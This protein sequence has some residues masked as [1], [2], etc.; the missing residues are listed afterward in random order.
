MLSGLWYTHVPNYVSLSWFWRC[1]KHP[2]PS[3]PALGLWRILEIPDWGLVLSWFGDLEDAGGSWLGFGIF[4]LIGYGHWS[5]IQLWSKFCL[6]ILSLKMQRTS[7]SFKSWFGALEDPG[8]SWLGFAI[9]ILTWIWSL[10]FDRPMFWIVA[11]YL[12]LEGAKN[13]HVL[14]VLIWGFGGCWRFL[15]WV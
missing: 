13:I 14:K 4:I 9:L 6:S 7:M 10:I 11:L 8:G 2:H 15:T 1:K 12:D 3:S 5:L